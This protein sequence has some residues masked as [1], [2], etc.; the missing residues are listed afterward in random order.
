MKCIFSKL[1]MVRF[2]N[3]RVENVKFLTKF[4]DITCFRLLFFLLFNT[5]SSVEKFYNSLNRHTKMT[6][7]RTNEENKLNALRISFFLTVLS[8]PSVLAQYANSSPTYRCMYIKT[9]SANF[10]VVLC[11][12]EQRICG[13]VRRQNTHNIPPVL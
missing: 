12:A 8:L 3:I 1:P 4:C 9:L 2:N 5:A 13:V 10:I 6:E 7:T 11:G